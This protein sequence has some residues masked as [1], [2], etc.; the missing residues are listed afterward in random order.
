MASQTYAQAVRLQP[1][2][3]AANEGLGR[4]LMSLDQ[5]KEAKPYLEHAVALDPTRGSAHYRLSLLDR[6]LGDSAAAKQEMDEF[7]RLREG[8]EKMS[9]H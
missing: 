4:A 1:D 5:L 9:R 2:D 6:R 7:V 3:P 8:Q